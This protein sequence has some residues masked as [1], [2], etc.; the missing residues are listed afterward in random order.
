MMQPKSSGNMQSTSG[1]DVQRKGPFG[2]KPGHGVLVVASAVAA[3]IVAFWAFSFITSILA[4]LVKVVVVVAVIAVVIKLV[5]GR[6][7][8]HGV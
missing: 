8:G 4:L 2:L 6:S 1:K 7:N 3:A 5:M